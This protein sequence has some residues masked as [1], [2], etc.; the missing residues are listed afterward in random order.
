MSST[1]K[2]FSILL[3]VLFGICLIRTFVIVNLSKKKLPKCSKNENHAFIEVDWKRWERF[4][5]TLRMETI[6]YEANEQ[7]KDELKKLVEYIIQAHPTIFKSKHVQYE[8]VN[9][10]SLLIHVQG[11]DKS[12]LPYL[13]AA[14]LDVVPVVEHEWSV[15]P[16]S[17]IENKDGTIVYGR[18]TLDD[19]GSLMAQLAALEYFL[20][21]GLVPQRSFYIAHGHDEEISGYQ[22]AK[23]IAATLKKKGVDRLH[24]VLDEGLVVT[25]GLFGSMNQ[26]LALVGVTEKGIAFFNLSVEIHGGH[27]SM[28]A[29][30][31][32]IGIMSGAISRLQSN[33]MPGRIDNLMTEMLESLAPEIG[34]PTNIVLSNIWLFKPLLCWL[35]S[36]NQMLQG[37]VRTTTAVT[38]MRGGMK[39]NVIP[40]S[41][42]AIVNHRIHPWDSLD[43]VL[44][45]DQRIINDDRVRITVLHESEPHPISPFSRSSSITYQLL[46][47]TIEQIFDNVIIGP[48]ALVANTDTR[49]YLTFSENIYR[50]NPMVLTKDEIASIHAK[51]ERISRDNFEKMINFYFHL[52]INSDR[53]KLREITDKKG[54]L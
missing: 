22:G 50:F 45:H 16:F 25:R 8:I 18:G 5:D 24:F 44:Q 30:E 20:E 19:K 6:S 43:D 40:S 12:L 27:S 31:T 17:A 32:A 4:K 23:H 47:D 48:A 28:P 52:M 38:I 10:Y 15:D 35:L 49:H 29:K 46:T 3:V 33:Q 54:E 26:D 39:G 53:T 36:N 9:G 37:G 51:N 21:I 2:Y 42:S 34:F 1:C 14:H 41:A 11:R 7:N 13:L